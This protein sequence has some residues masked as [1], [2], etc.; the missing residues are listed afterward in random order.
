MTTK[1]ISIAEVKELEKKARE[2]RR[3]EMRKLLAD[4]WTL[5]QVGQ[6]YGVKRQRVSAIVGPVAKIRRMVAP[7]TEKS[8][9]A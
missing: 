4:G 6:K 2:Q 1:R 9:V 5:E 7:A 3:D 8:V